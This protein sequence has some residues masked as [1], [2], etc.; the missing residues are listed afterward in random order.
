MVCPEALEA[1]L[2]VSQD[3]VLRL[4]VGFRLNIHLVPY[5]F[6]GPR[7]DLFASAVNIRPCRIQVV[8]AHVHA[9]ADHLVFGREV[10]PIANLRYP[11][12][13]AAERSV[14]GRRR[15]GLGVKQAVRPGDSR[16]RQRRRPCL[17][18]EIPCGSCRAIRQTFPLRTRRAPLP[19][20]PP[21]V[22]CADFRGEFFGPH[23]YHPSGAGRFPSSMNDHTVRKSSG[24][25]RRA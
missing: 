6:D 22:T 23:A 21:L 17:L 20:L 15:W 2:H 7:Y 4:S 14:H 13:R 24:T 18:S 1:G 11:Q 10:G 12:T 8:D 25:F 16:K 3:R 5:T 9:R 19:F